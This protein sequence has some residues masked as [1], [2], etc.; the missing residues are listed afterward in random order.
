[1]PDSKQH[2]TPNFSTAPAVTEILCFLVKNPTSFH[3]ND[4]CKLAVVSFGPSMGINS[5]MPSKG[6][7]LYLPQVPPASSY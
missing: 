7:R 4:S 6:Y 1:L 2:I 5:W 3:S